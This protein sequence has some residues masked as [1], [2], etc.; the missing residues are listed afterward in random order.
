MRNR[1]ALF[2][3]FLVI[4]GKCLSQRT[5]WDIRMFSFFDNNEFGHSSVQIPQTMA[6][7]RF[8]PN[9]GL[10]WDSVN[11]VITGVNLLHEYGSNKFIGNYYPTAYYKFDK[12]PFVFL[13]GAFPRSFIHD[14]YPRLFFQDS[15]I[16]YRPNVNGIMIEYS[17][18]KLRLGLWLDWTG[19]QA[20]DTRET[21]LLGVS[22]KYKPGILYLRH[23]SYLFHF[24]GPIN[25]VVNEALHDNGLAL[26]SIGLDFT[27]KTLL[28]KFEISAGWAIGL[29]RARADGTGWFTHSGFLSETTIEFKR[30][31]LFNSLYLGDGQMYY[32]EDHDN[33]LYWGDPFYR[34]KAYNRSDFYIDFIKDKR[35]SVRLIYSLHFAESRMYHEQALK[36]SVNLNNLRFNP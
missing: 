27:G 13:M 21:F 22:G 11:S 7:V 35:T 34:A 31:G 15:I 5:I 32:Y 28:D 2:L 19:R 17:S 20:I 9:I 10:Q 16:Y 12:K 29:D 26:T 3:L 4:S 6:G 23:L 8:A 1:I 24:S 25:P 36:V 33:E 14:M 18:K 30:V